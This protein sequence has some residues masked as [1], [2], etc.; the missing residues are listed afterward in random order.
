MSNPIDRPNFE[1]KPAYLG[2]G[3]YIQTTPWNGDFLLT[4]GSHIP[5]QAEGQIVITSDI[6]L[7]LVKSLQARRP[8]LFR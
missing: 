3:V 5:T 8:E 4:L 1:P 7:K 2:D 6:A